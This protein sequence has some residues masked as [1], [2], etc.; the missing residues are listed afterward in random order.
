LFDFS[1][2]AEILCIKIRT[3]SDALLWTASSLGC[4]TTKSAHHLYTAQRPL[5]FS[6]VLAYSWKGL[7][8][9][10]LTHRFKLFLWKMVWNIVPTKS[11]ISLSIHSGL[12]TSCSLCSNSNNSLLHLFFSCP[13]TR[14]IWRNSFWP[15]DILALHISFMFDWLNIILHLEMIGIPL[16]DTHFFQIFAMVAC[17]RIWFSRNKAFH[18]GLIPNALFVSSSVNQVSRA[19]SLLG[20]IKLL[21]LSRYGRNLILVA[22]R[23][24]DTTI[25]SNFSVQAA[26]C[27][28]SNGFII[29]C[30]TKI[31][32]PCTPLYG[33]ATVALLA[34]QLC[35]SM[36]LSHVI[37]E[38]DSLTVN[39][40]INNSTIT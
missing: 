17:D 1:S 39:L 10:K 21:P 8:K 32:P 12:D 4:F 20:L 2:V 6:P 3:L 19:H 28:D 40:A 26:V 16:V 37:F 11:R 5:Q 18:E 14:V 35:S 22:S 30:I 29:Q 25:R 34:A 23:L 33:E 27:R 15:L 24:T 38:G 13:I 36:Q 31:S 7:W 9:L